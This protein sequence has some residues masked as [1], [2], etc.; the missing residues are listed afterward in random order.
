MDKL[1]KDSIENKPDPNKLLEW[2]DYNARAMPWRVP[3]EKRLKGVLPNP[4]HVWLSEI[5]L[6][7][8]TVA[9][10]KSYFIK[11]ITKWP[12]IFDLANAR[13]EEIMG[14]WAGLGY[15]ARA[16]NLL[17]CARVIV[18]ESD[19]EFP[20]TSEALLKLPGVG[21]YTAAAIASIAYDIPE[22]VVD[23]NV[24]RVISR[25]FNIHTKL[26]KAK[27]ELAFLAKQLTPKIR[28]GDYAQAIMD[29]GATICKP[30]SPKCNI[31]PWVYYCVSNKAGTSEY[32]PRKF[33]KPIKQKRYGIVYFVERVD[34][35][36]LTEVRPANGLLGGMLSLPSSEWGTSFTE[37]P[38]IEG[39]WELKNGLI[40]HTFTHFLLNLRIMHTTSDL[41]QPPKRG[42]FLSLDE[43][44]PN[45][46]PTVM[47][48]VWKLIKY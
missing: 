10:V 45:N 19:G 9:S 34:G 13:D 4:Y 27:K 42:K 32:L 37:D 46:L 2:Y 43:F 17:K 29:L 7:Q 31:C 18:K 8:T 41:N 26:P 36:I 11:F 3:P 20:K 22:T 39:T 47:K 6:Q 12:T 44:N 40:K 21:P 23:G 15:Y 16:R 28:S 25:I 30:T 24:E 5:M 14:A 48:K 38:P 35:A 1:M 33:K